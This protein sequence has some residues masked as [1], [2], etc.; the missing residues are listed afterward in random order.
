MYIRNCVDSVGMVLF[1]NPFKPVRLEREINIYHVRDRLES[2]RHPV[3]A[4]TVL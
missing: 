4:C 2:G 1:Q 3:C